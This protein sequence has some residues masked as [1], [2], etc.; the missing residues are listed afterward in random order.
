MKIVQHRPLIRD[1]FLPVD[2]NVALIRNRNRCSDTPRNGF[3]CS[4]FESA[5]VPLSIADPDSLNCRL[6]AEFGVASMMTLP[7]PSAS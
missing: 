3:D 1:L 4:E 5:M 7:P 2:F 6:E